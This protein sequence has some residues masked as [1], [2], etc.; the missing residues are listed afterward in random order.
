[1]RNSFSSN[2]CPISAKTSSNCLAPVKYKSWSLS[3]IPGFSSKIAEK[4]TKSGFFILQKVDDE[5]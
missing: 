2:L 3:G 5:N 4:W 1:M